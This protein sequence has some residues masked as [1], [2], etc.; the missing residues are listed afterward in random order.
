M[1]L[2]EL[3]ARTGLAISTLSKLEKGHASLSF[4]KLTAIS[5]ALGVDIAELLSESSAASSAGTGNPARARR[6]I[7]RK[8]EG[9]LVET[10][11]YRQ[12]YL[13]AD[14]LHKGMTPM[15]VEI[16]ARTMEEFQ[17]EF[18][19]LIRHDGE[20][21][22]HVLSGELDFHSDVYAPLRLRAGD[23][24]YFDSDMG[25]AYLKVGDATCM[26]VD[27]CVSRHADNAML[28]DF[29]RVAQLHETTRTASPKG[30]RTR[31][32]VAS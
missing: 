21:F 13:A 19:G 26:V 16:R 23:S 9:M 17:A 14:L 30:S 20:E 27:V 5:K 15:V 11:S 1:T 18:G 31:A 28:K 32:P 6:C 8:G 10:G 25:H 24:L 7:Q 3:G 22:V 12:L 4:D 2:S 29:Q